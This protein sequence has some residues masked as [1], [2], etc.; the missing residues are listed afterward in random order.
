MPLARLEAGL[1]AGQPTVRVDEH[2]ALF[3]GLA[4][5]PEV[6]PALHVSED[7]LDLRRRAD[8]LARL[9]QAAVVAKVD[10]VDPQAFHVQAG[11]DGEI[12]ARGLGR[13]R[14]AGIE[15][16]L[17]HTGTRDPRIVGAVQPVLVGQ[18]RKTALAP[19]FAPRVLNEEAYVVVADKRERMAAEGPGID[20]ALN[21]VHLLAIAL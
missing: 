9:G 19:Q 12:A 8:E 11:S 16:R 17:R 6:V 1:F 13:A 20:G 7:S 4:L 15:W 14:A 18:R 21:D 5:E 3:D 10:N 2:V